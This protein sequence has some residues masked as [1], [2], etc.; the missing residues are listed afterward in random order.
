MIKE[1]RKEGFGFLRRAFNEPS[2]L[3]DLTGLTQMHQETLDAEVRL[4]PSQIL[5]RRIH[6]L[7]S[8][9]VAELD[10]Y[11]MECGLKNLSF[12]RPLWWIKREMA[13]K[14]ARN[15]IRLNDAEHLLIYLIEN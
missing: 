5:V 4:S 10:H 8:I 9:D 11:L 3:E 12:S 7:E 15:Q 6:N 2:Y 14:K 13:K 1:F